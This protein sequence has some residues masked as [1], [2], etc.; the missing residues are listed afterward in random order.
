MK[1]DIEEG[2]GV[3][4]RYMEVVWSRLVSLKV[5]GEKKVEDVVWVRDL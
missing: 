4:L 1:L 5:E 2:H 3:N